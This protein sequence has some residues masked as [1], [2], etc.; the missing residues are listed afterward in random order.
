MASVD[1]KINEAARLNFRLPAEIKKRVER[2]AMASGMTVT[3]FA[4]SALTTSADEVLDRLSQRKLSDRDRDIFLT[5]IENPPKPNE[6]LRRAAQTY[7]KR[8]K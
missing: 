3:D 5:M 1:I 6:A 8:A 7:K 4:V 2:A